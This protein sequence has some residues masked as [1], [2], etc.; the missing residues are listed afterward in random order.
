MK[1]S[2]QAYFY[3][4]ALVI[5]QRGMVSELRQR[6]PTINSTSV[7]VMYIISRGTARKT[8]GTCRLGHCYLDNF[9]W[10]SVK[11]VKT[12]QLE[13]STKSSGL[14]VKYREDF[15][16][17]EKTAVSLHYCRTTSSD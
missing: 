5:Q 3:M 14:G 17:A 13:R 6:Q 16:E 11:R 10:H 12:C 4:L 7:T 1:H 2:W 9:T 8:L 15:W